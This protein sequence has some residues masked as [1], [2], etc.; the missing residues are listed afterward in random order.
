[1]PKLERNSKG[2]VIIKGKTKKYKGK[3]I[4]KGR[5][6]KR[7]IQRSRGID[8]LTILR[9]IVYSLNIFEVCIY[10]TKSTIIL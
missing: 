9:Y 10:Q 3:H 8:K 2:R 1:M 6:N 4:Y 7:E 5:T